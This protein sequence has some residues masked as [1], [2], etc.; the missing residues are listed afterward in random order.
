MLYIIYEGVYVIE[1]YKEI[2][3]SLFCHLVL[4]S[5]HSLSSPL[6]LQK[7]DEGLAIGTVRRRDF[8]FQQQCQFI[9]SCERLLT[10]GGL[11]KLT[12]IYL[13]SRI[14]DL[15]N[16]EVL[17]VLYLENISTASFRFTNYRFNRV[18]NKNREN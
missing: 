1:D 10:V 18:A 17:L 2:F 11:R 8:F 9:A 12:N 14:Q 16:K 5:M 4:N 3:L 6:C 15:C 13:T 7:R